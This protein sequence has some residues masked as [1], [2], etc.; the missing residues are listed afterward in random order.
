MR[1][2]AGYSTAPKNP[3]SLAPTRGARQGYRTRLETAGLLRLFVFQRPPLTRG[4]S[5]Y[6]VIHGNKIAHYIHGKNYLNR[7]HP[8]DNPLVPEVRLELPWYFGTQHI[9]SAEQLT[10]VSTLTCHDSRQL[11][12]VMRNINSIYVYKR[13]DSECT[14]VYSSVSQKTASHAAPRAAPQR[15]RASTICHHQ[16]ACDIR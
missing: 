5:F 10:L 12:H 15:G 2:L 14:L 6:C 9:R 11:Y 1:V 13:S 8:S 7:Y 4:S 16:L 3:G